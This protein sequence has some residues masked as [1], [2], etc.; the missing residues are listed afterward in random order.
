MKKLFPFSLFVICGLFI[1]Q[2][3]DEELF[4]ISET[5]VFENEFTVF[6]SDNKFVNA[7]VVDL[8]GQNDVIADYGSKIKKI[9]IQKVRYWLKSHNGSSSQR[10]DRILVQVAK[11]DQT[12]IETLIQL[13]NINLSQ[14]V[15]SPQQFAYNQQ[16]AEVLAGLIENQPHQFA[17]L[18]ATS[19]NEVPYDFV[20]VVEITAKMTAN[21]L[22]KNN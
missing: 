10:V 7:Q 19:G 20:L 21:P 8:A 11:P 22:R 18:I 4:D 5:V 13:D 17:Y 15:A 1:F 2:S 14:L 6:T 9:E 3:C 12:G 16:G